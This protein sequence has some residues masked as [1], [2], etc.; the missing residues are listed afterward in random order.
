MLDRYGL[1]Y[2]AIAAYNAGPTPVTN[3]RSQRPELDADFWIETI[4]Y[5]ETREY[6]SRVLIFTALYDWR[7]H[8]NAVPLSQRLQGQQNAQRK[9]FVCQS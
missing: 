1:A 2:M 5:R 6:V 3:W 7:M 4:N 8:G 9:N